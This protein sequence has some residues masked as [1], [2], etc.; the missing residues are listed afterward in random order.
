M[1]GRVPGHPA[2]GSPMRGEAMMLIPASCTLPQGRG[3]GGSLVHEP[4]F[5]SLWDYCSKRVMG[6]HLALMPGVH[7]GDGALCSCINYMR[8]STTYNTSAASWHRPP[9]MTRHLEL[10]RICV[11]RLSTS[12]CLLGGS[13]T[14]LLRCPFIT[15]QP[16]KAA[17]E[18]PLSSTRPPLC[19]RA[20]GAHARSGNPSAGQDSPLEPLPLSSIA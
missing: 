6:N 1:L 8:A 14:F 18:R 20:A 10:Q 13:R 19:S 9:L 15:T 11:P 4:K 5:R 3:D 2:A 16:F 12:F 7:V 17:H